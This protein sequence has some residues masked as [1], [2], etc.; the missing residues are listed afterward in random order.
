MHVLMVTRGA[1]LTA[2]FLQFSS[3]AS[4][5]VWSTVDAGLR[6][7]ALGNG[8]SPR[9]RAASEK[10]VVAAMFACGARLINDG[11]ENKE[12]PSRACACPSA[13]RDAMRKKATPARN[14]PA[15][16]WECKG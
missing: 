6:P 1:A 16:K 2:T 15:Q 8:Y 12:R 11:L 5:S 10:A 9:K 3:T 14:H 4:I 13:T 7:M